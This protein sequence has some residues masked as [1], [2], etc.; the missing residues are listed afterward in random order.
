MGRFDGAA[1]GDVLGRADG[2]G[3]GIPEGWALGMTDGI[4]VE[5]RVGWLVIVDCD[6]ISCSM[7]T[8]SVIE[9]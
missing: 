1:E 5:D 2:T 8:I 3:E 4:S 7:T 6:I 9:S